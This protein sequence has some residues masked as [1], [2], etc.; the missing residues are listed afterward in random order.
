M[1]DAAT[2]GGPITA[3]QFDDWLAE[4]KAEARAGGWNDALF[5]AS[6]DGHYV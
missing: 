2:G 3:A 1:R 5:T 4:V 6:Q